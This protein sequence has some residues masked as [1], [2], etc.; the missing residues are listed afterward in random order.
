MIRNYKKN[1]IKNI[2]ITG[3]AGYI[4]SHMVQIAIDVGYNVVV[5]DNL[6]KGHKKSVHKKAKLIIGDIAD[7]NLVREALKENQIDVVMHFAAFIDA[8]ESVLNPE[9]YYHNNYEKTKSL[10]DVV[11]ESGVNYFVF[12][13]TAAIFGDAKYFPIDEDHP[14]NPT[15]P[16]GESKLMVEKYLEDFQETHQNFKYGSLRYFNVGGSDYKNGLGNYNSD[17]GLINLLT[18]FVIGEIDNFYIFGDDYDTR[19]GTCIRDYIHVLDICDAHLKLL[20]YLESGGLEKY[21][22]IGSKNGHS[23]SEIV[24]T[25]EQIIDKKLDIR[26]GER[27]KREIIKSIAGN[28]KAKE[29]LGWELRN[30]NLRNII[31]SALQ[32]GKVKSE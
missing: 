28:K 14:K 1:S 26:I 21:F 16:Y 12:S 8:E 23:I 19:D 5:L 3:G 10:I 4:G 6:S 32:W 31:Y 24:K 7:E 15:N 20:K 22:N 29:I 25:T 13:S 2:L 27:R 11:I 30:S 9:K 17:R 18:R